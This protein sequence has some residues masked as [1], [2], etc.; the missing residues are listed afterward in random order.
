MVIVLWSDTQSTTT[1]TVISDRPGIQ[2]DRATFE[3]SLTSAFQQASYV[4]ATS[5]LAIRLF[6][7]IQRLVN[8]C[9]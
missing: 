3:T 6:A 7:V 9:K 8:V 5:R 2:V 1:E 4:V